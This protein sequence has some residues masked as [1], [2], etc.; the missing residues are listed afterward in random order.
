MYIFNYEYT[1][2]GS[3]IIWIEYKTKSINEHD[4]GFTKFFFAFFGFF[5]LI[6]DDNWL[7]NVEKVS[8]GELKWWRNTQ[9]NL[10]T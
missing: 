8:K 10:L 1:C 7:Y 5:F 2:D 4:E 9:T 3:S 6:S